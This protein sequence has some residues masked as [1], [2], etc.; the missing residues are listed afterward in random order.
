MRSDL[1]AAIG[2]RARSRNANFFASAFAVIAGALL[3]APQGDAATLALGLQ[4]ACALTETGTA[5]CW[6]NNAYRQLGDGTTTDRLTPVDAAVLTVPVT[7]LAVGGNHACGLTA[8]GGV[9]CWGYNRFGQLGNGSTAETPSAVD[10]AGLQSGVAAIAAGR[11]HSCALTWA[12]AV[13]CWGSNER[14]QLGDGST[15][16][17][18]LPVDVVGLDAGIVAIAAGG[19]G[20]CAITASGTAKC[21]GDNANG[22]LGDGT[23]DE[24]HAPVDVVGLAG[25][26]A[27]AMGEVHACARLGTGELKCWGVNYAGQLGDGTTND[28]FVPVGVQA[29]G[30]PALAVSLGYDHT[31]ALTS[32]GA[33]KCWGNNTEGE[34]GDGTYDERHLPTTVQGLA[35]DVTELATTASPSVTCARLSS[36][37]LRCWG[38][39]THGERGDG[40]PSQRPLAQGV[41]GLNQGTLAI[42]VGDLHACAL[43]AGGAVKCW[44]DG[45][46]GALGDSM[47]T[48]RPTPAVVP[49]IDAAATI[50]AGQGH[51]C[52]STTAGM[53]LCWGEGGSGQLG[54][55]SY[56]RFSWPVIVTGMETGTAAFALGSRH[57]CALTDAGGVKCWGD[58]MYGQLGGGTDIH[59][60]VPVDVK[61]LATGV[62]AIAAGD[63]HTC[64]V[65]TVG[66]VKCW[67]YNDMGELGDGTTTT[68]FTPVDVVQLN[69]PAV[70]LAAGDGYTCALTDAGAVSCWGAGTV[71]LADVASLGSDVVKIFGGTLH[72]CALMRG[73]GLKCWGDNH[74]GQLGDGTFIARASPVDVV[75]LTSG[76]VS[77]SASLDATCAVTAEG[78][79]R[80]WGDNALGQLG[81]GEAGYAST[82]RTVVGTPF[83]DL[84]FRNGFD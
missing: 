26:T 82:P 51:T 62:A 37:E 43:V 50:S 20:S 9:K 11:R 30:A 12:G 5:K 34:L 41:V 23:T 67:G 59:S 15:T 47:W 18:A 84:L 16:D 53:A 49:D 77:A 71:A 58:N 63:M 17:S 52:T 8:N 28:S 60:A 25:A 48:P 35:A 70:A 64:V 13:K 33:V 65:T 31:C 39:G 46:F 79:A 61:G 45:R 36:G 81:N 14:G 72:A 22:Q 42:A 57:S 10:V 73:G 83:M 40:I 76:V 3:A 38:F 4:H 6:G 1:A 66:S 80:C 75:G 2:V 21:W 78:A 56:G 74:Y 32:A 19:Y 27:L 7:T 29:L 69:A 24:A 54:N 44:G 55:G 68:R